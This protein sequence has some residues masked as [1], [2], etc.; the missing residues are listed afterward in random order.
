MKIDI[1]LEPDSPERFAELGR[2]AEGCGIGAV[3][4]ANHMG[5]RDPFMCFMPLAQSSESVRMG[6]V[7]VSPV[8]LHPLKICNQLLTLNEYSDGRANIVIGGGGGTIIAMGLKPGRREMVPRMVG[9]VA[10][11]IGF[12]KL[13]AR[14]ERVDWDGDFFSVSGYEPNWV[15]HAPPLVYVGASKPQMLRMAARIADGVMMSD[16]PLQRIDEAVAALGGGLAAAGREPSAFRTSNLYSWHVKADRAEAMRE[17]RAKLFVRGMLEHWYISPFLE[18]HE[19][20]LVEARFDAFAKAYASNSPEIEGVPDDIVERLVEHLTFTGD[21]N[22]VE[23]LTEKLVGFRDA[24]LNEFGIRLYDRPEDAIRLL[25]ER[26][27]PALAAG[28]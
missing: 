5:A 25:G 26:V 14:G 3:W 19:C 21:L 16:V 2:L 8:E 22:D 23:R 18:P 28:G 17:A 7:A 24:G 12:L 4:T 13:A 11:C 10:D 9:H 15:R 6:P 1:I 20:E 27:I